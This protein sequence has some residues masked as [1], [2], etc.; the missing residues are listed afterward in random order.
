[1]TEV[2]SYR[3]ENQSD[4]I[5]GIIEINSPPVNALS[6][7]VRKGIMQCLEEFEK[8]QDAKISAH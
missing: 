6:I 5:V 2:V 7:F 3:R 1:M 4:L 8:D